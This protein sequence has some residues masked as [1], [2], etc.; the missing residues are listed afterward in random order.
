[1]GIMEKKM[2]AT[3]FL[4]LGFRV[5]VLGFRALDFRVCRLSGLEV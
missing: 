2:E 4:G 1:M 3:I 5:Q